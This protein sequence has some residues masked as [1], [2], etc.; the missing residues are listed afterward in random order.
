MSQNETPDEVGSEFDQIE[1]E[2]DITIDEVRE[3]DGTLV[4]NVIDDLV[5]IAA[6]EGSVVEETIDV[7]D[8]EGHLIVEEEIVTVYDADANVVSRDE[9]I[10][11][12]IEELA[13]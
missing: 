7:V 5:V 6:P 8:L 1:V 10:A 2:E 4:A 9:T 11:I 12:P 13:P 3:N